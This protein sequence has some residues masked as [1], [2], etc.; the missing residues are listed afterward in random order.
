MEIDDP[1]IGKF[2]EYIH[3]DK[4]KAKLI[5][6]YN[7]TLKDDSAGN[8]EMMHKLFCHFLL[9]AYNET[10]YLFSKHI[11]EEVG[12]IEGQYENDKMDAFLDMLNFL[13]KIDKFTL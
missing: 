7:Y 12:K 9:E 4:F 3:S 5:K 6:T 13:K 11:G 1:I 2:K 10:V 8:P